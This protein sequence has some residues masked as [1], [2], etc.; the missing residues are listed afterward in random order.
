MLVNTHARL[1][2][3]IGAAGVHLPAYGPAPSRIR[4][5]Y[6]NQL[7]IGRSTHNREECREA[8]GADFITFGPIYSPGSKPGYRSRRGG[9]GPAQRHGM[10]AP[11]RLRPGRY[12]TRT[13]RRLQGKRRRGRCR[14]VGNP[15]RGRYPVGRNRLCR[16]LGVR[17]RPT[18]S[19][20][21]MKQVL[22]IAGS[23]P[24]GGAGIQADLKSFHANGVYGLSVIT[25]V[26][27]QNTKE[28]RQTFELP[29]DLDR[30]PD[31]RGVR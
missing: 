28:V 17:T 10:L 29:A 27:A 23:D 21:F 24:G 4:Q 8:Y 3:D 12:H 7:L 31:R 1:A 30:I 19:A 22:T 6:G 18:S 15:R 25:A 2:R 16:G 14:Y 26:T 9:R 11:S 13:G 20:A 5:Q